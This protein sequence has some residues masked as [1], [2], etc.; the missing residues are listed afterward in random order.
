[1]VPL[2]DLAR[3]KLGLKTGA[4]KFF[5]LEAIGKGVSTD[6]LLGKRRGGIKVRGFNGW[7]GE[8]AKADLLPVAR[9]PHDLQTSTGRRFRIPKGGRTVYLFPRDHAPALDLGGYVEVGVR[10][11]VHLQK[12]VQD[13]ASDSRWYRQVRAVV[14]SDWALPYNSAYD[15]GA[16]D[17]TADAV[18]NG[19]F[20]GVE[21]RDGVDG[22]L[23]GA[24][25]NTTM[26]MAARLLEGTTTGVEG[27]FDVGPPA[28]RRMIVPDVRLVSGAA[29]GEI[30]ACLEEWRQGDHMSPGPDDHAGVEPLRQRLDQLM[31]VALGMTPG[32]AS[33]FTSRLY[34]D[35]ARWRS[36][37]SAVEM[38]MR[39]NRSA[40]SAS[41]QSRGV[42]PDDAA[43]QHVWEEI[44]ADF[45]PLPAALLDS[46]DAVEMIDVSRHLQ[47]PAQEALFEPGSVP[48]SDGK[49][50]DL[51]SYDRVRYA[52]MLI[53][54]GFQPPLSIPTDPIRAA[55]IVDNYDTTLTKLRHRARGHAAAYV[56]ESAY[57]SVVAQV[58]RNW[59]R[60]C[61]HAGMTPKASNA[62]VA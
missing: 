6:D 32:E 27:A 16:W 50:H 53:G 44:E 10:A 29:E 54:I 43:A 38:M 15:Y 22:D 52:A 36:A 40:M 20:V 46:E 18:L 56:S 48:L 45:D 60:A 28:A 55:A 11:G 49:H 33:A 47:P 23:L 51:G 61:R 12:L 41:G 31:L 4:D 25:L 5:Y 19:R 42:R 21:A 34:T 17:N 13:N 3:T 37:V 1:M 14:R 62:T 58:T 7:E 39:V 8:V 30:R 2:D 57:V 35:Y 9:N 24:A 26:V 59:H